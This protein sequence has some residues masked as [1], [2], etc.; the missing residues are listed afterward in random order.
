MKLPPKAKIIRYLFLGLLFALFL[1]M[2]FKVKE[3]FFQGQPN[4][5]ME[6]LKTTLSG[7]G[8]A[9]GKA[10]AG[11]LAG[12]PPAS[13]T[14]SQIS[15]L[16]AI[17]LSALTTEQ[18]STT[19]QVRA[20]PTNQAAALTTTQ[21][22]ALP[23]NQ[24]L[25]TTQVGGLTTDQVQTLTTAQLGGLTTAQVSTLPAAQ[26]SGTS[27]A[28]TFSNSSNCANGNLAIGCS[29]VSGQACNGGATCVNGRCELPVM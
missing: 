16:P 2:F 1:T 11:K 3:G 26:L 7:N 27:T 6:S 23:T 19:N 17:Q 24:A 8:P 13:K 15:T 28:N 22:G 5:G 20:L 25:T 12:P 10:Q 14:P 4:T 9:S 21:V 18:V 29:C